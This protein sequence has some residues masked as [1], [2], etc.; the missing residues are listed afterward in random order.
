MDKQAEALR[1]AEWLENE[2]GYDWDKNYCLTVAELRRLHQVNQEL[3]EALEGLMPYIATQATGCYGDKCREP[4]CFSCNGADDAFA[5]AEKGQDACAKA[6][7]VL[8]K[9]KEQA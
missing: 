7:E 6:S 3:V 8:A 2:P 4:W 5:A 1:L 9:H